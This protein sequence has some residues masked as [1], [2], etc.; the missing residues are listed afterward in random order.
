MTIDIVI[1]V[2]ERGGVENVINDTAL[3][4]KEDGWIVRIVQLV[5]E[6]INWTREGILFFPLLYGRAGHNLMEF[7][8]AYMN[9]LHE[10]G[11]PDIVLATA[12][13]Y[14][15]Y[16]AQKA[17]YGE[18]TIPVISWLHAPVERYQAAGYGGYE[19]LRWADG[20]F[21]ISDYIYR[22]IEKHNIS[23]VVRVYNPVDFSRV[24]EKYIMQQDKWKKLFY[25]GRISEEKHI[26]VVINAIKLADK[27]WKLYIVGDGEEEYV[28]TLKTQAS[29]MKLADRVFW[30]GWKDNPWVYAQQADAIVLASE[31][32]GAPLSVIEALAC[33]KTII[34]TPINGVKEL[35]TP[36]ETGYLFDWNDFQMLAEI[37]NYLQEGILP[38]IDS[39]RCRGTVEQYE[40]EKALKN[41]QKRICEF[42]K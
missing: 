40:K 41:F 9:F 11:K 2:A 39:E 34:T 8:E 3:Y 18:K 31:Y 29:Q 16:V 32:E 14:M 36:G 23:K 42:L 19:S 24:N 15:S 7:T 26:E 6:G 27:N 21:A 38:F 22:E 20:H 1:A 13:P 17:V 30:L 28:N 4:L 12:W 37:L 25:V 10:K 33:G 35:I 5:W